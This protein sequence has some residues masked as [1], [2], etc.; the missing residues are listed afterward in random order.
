MDQ[1]TRL[2]EE[3][4]AKLDAADIIAGGD[5]SKLATEIV[6]DV[7]LPMMGARSIHPG[8]PDHPATQVRA[9]GT[10]PEH[11]LHRA[12]YYATPGEDNPDIA[13][14]TPERE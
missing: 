9:V 4:A 13:E 1:R 7:I 12:S 6:D 3:I 5:P 10:D 2:I 14:K 8:D 11:E